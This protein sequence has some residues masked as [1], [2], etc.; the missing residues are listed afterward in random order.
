VAFGLT[1]LGGSLLTA[2]LLL[3]ENDTVALVVYNI[4]LAAA[5]QNLV[6]LLSGYLY[7]KKQDP[8]GARG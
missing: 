8:K 7:P 3:N 2:P 6:G 5:G 1:E 4:N